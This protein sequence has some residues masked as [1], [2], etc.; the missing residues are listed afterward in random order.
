[1]A[2]GFICGRGRG[3][4]LG[5]LELFVDGNVSEKLSTYGYPE[6]VAAEARK[7]ATIGKT[8]HASVPI[9]GRGQTGFEAKGIIFDNISTIQLV[10]SNIT[11]ENPAGGGRRTADIFVAIYDPEVFNS[12][13]VISSYIYNSQRYPF[14][15]NFNLSNHLTAG[16]EYD[17]EL[18]T[19]PDGED[20]NTN[21]GPTIEVSRI[22]LLPM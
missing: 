3:S 9:G 8:L 4:K 14:V 15:F 1:M 19:T 20:P 12:Q 13:P 10:I 17:F 11:H 22:S 2:E 7:R 5:P 18:I 21:Y 16:K 6:S